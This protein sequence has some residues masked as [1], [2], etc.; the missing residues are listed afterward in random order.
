VI[1]QCNRMLKYNIMDLGKIWYWVLSESIEVS[2]NVAHRLNILSD[3]HEDRNK[4]VFLK[5]T[6]H[7]SAAPLLS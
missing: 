7:G 5:T 4:F 3:L 2:Q 1:L 6:P